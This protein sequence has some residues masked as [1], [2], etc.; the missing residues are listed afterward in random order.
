MVYIYISVTF[1]LIWPAEYEV[2]RC[3]QIVNL[4]RLSPEQ[5]CIFCHNV[6]KVNSKNGVLPKQMIQI[7]MN[8]R[9]ELLFFF[10]MAKLCLNAA[11]VSKTS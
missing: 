2:H 7:Q 9:L 11:L 4:R 3:N 6:P 8:E 10:C 5:N 1:Y